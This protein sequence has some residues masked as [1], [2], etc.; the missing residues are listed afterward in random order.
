MSIH[1]F[2]GPVCTMWEMKMLFLLKYLLLA[3]VPIC[4]NPF[5]VIID[6]SKL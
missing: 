5:K 3:F 1:L 6:S 2:N 4:V